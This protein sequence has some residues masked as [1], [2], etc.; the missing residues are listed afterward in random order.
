MKC[1]VPFH[2]QNIVAATSALE[3]TEFYFLDVKVKS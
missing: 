2:V 3:C 1:Y